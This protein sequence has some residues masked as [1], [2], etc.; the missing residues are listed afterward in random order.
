M[1]QS[2]ETVF[3]DTSLG[4]IA[5]LRRDGVCRFRGVPFAEAPVGA[6]RFCPPRRKTPW[7]GTLEAFEPGVIAPQLASR[8]LAVM[9]DFTRRQSEDCLRLDIVTPGVD[10]ARR[11]VV[12]W[13]HGG[14]FS[15]GAGG[16]DWYDG[17]LLAGEGDVVVV[18]V[19]YR[20]GALGYLVAPGISDGN[21]GL[22]DQALA[23]R[24]V[25]D[26]V[27]GFGGDPD[28][29]TLMGQSAGGN[30]IAALFAGGHPMKGVRRAIMQSAAL[31]MRPQDSVRAR[32]LGADFVS[33]L[34]G[35]PDKPDETRVK[36]AELPVSA[37]LG[38]QAAVARRHARFGDTAPPFQLVQ[39][40]AGLSDTIAFDHAAAD[41]MTG[42]DVL[43]GVTADEADAFFAL[44]PRAGELDASAV[45]ELVGELYG[46]RGVG[47]L[48]LMARRNGDIAPGA[49]LSAVV[50][51]DV[52][53]EPAI[54]F[55]C[56]RA[57]DGGKAYVYE[58]GWHPAG[59]PLGACHCLELPFV[60]GPAQAWGDA[61]MLAGADPVEIAELSATMR[62]AWLNF[63]RTGDPAAAKLPTW[64]IFTAGR[65]NAMRL[66]RRSAIRDL[67]GDPC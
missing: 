49:L 59:S 51:Q 4:R 40:S 10:D 52:F 38:A 47:A 53:V 62:A 12:V 24:V 30:S 45:A 65:K 50:T 39:A 58:F 26:I 18:G 23:L 15:S 56:R 32:A 31:G 2:T 63:V 44:D 64:P 1:R 20:L 36:L 34:G 54:A 48:D 3:V 9:G 11:P 22:L 16:L 29:I 28:N 27:A 43:I 46:P 13:L 14:G 25:R 8:L 55:A 19:N 17:G 33:E 57:A 35:D 67:A 5:G 41:A 37:I 42:I 7:T 66:D 21:L 61:P 6:L 60:F